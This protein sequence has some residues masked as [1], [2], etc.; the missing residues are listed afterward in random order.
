M[1]VGDSFLFSNFEL[2]KYLDSDSI[3]RVD[4]L[5]NNQEHVNFEG[6]RMFIRDDAQH[7][8][9]LKHFIVNTTSEKQRAYAQSNLNSMKDKELAT[10]TGSTKE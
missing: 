9:L 3:S 4:K 10:V 1:N 7:L 6:V 2:W 5:P 8:D